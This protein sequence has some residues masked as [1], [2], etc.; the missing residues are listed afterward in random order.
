MQT[1]TIPQQA[2]LLADT[3]A[4]IQKPETSGTHPDVQVT[5]TTNNL[6]GTL[7]MR[8]YQQSQARAN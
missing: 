3:K 1:K 6:L 5:R 8:L 2:A 7:F 4:T